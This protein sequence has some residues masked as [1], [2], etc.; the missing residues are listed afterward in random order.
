[1][2]Q[3]A[4][5]D[6]TTAAGFA[7]GGTGGPLINKEKP[8]ESRLLKVVGYQDK[9]KMPPTGK[10]KDEEL[11]ALGEWVKLGAPW[12]PA[13]VAQADEA[14]PTAPKST[15]EFAAEEKAFWAFQ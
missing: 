7:K 6:L 4:E 11:A 2:T 8:V 10:L 15:R 9:L 1:T 3:V 13:A 12:P 5:L 14:K